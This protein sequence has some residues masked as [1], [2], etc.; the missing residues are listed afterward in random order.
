[1]KNFLLDVKLP[2][3]TVSEANLSREHWT[4]KH[5]RHK[6]QK[7]AIKFCLSNRIK[8]IPLPCILKLTRIAPRKLDYDNLCCCFKVLND[9]LCDLI[10]PGLKPG[11]SDGTGQ[12][13]TEYYQKRGLPHEY[14][15][16]IQIVS[17]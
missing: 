2:I 6:G 17:L 7:E 14:A 16:E 9:S 1:M 11:R 8:N 13:K 15:I 3:K 4:K 5:K 10:I 12:I